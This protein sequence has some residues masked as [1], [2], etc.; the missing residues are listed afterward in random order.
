MHSRSMWQ[1]HRPHDVTHVLP[2]EPYTSSMTSYTCFED[3][4]ASVPLAQLRP[5]VAFSRCAAHL[6]HDVDQLHGGE[7][8][9]SLEITLTVHSKARVVLQ[10]WVLLIMRRQVDARQEKDA[11]YDRLQNTAVSPQEKIRICQAPRCCATCS[12]SVNTPRLI[13]CWTAISSTSSFPGRR[14]STTGMTR[15]ICRPTG[16]LFCTGCNRRWTT[17]SRTI[18]G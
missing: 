6:P 8:V 1:H 3:L 10:C 4:E 12:L 17:C 16:R 7:L 15:S 11:L 2:T 5:S 18:T 13:L 9:Q 14:R